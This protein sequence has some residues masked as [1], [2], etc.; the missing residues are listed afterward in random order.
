MEQ[1]EAVTKPAPA[2]TPD[3]LAAKAIYQC[4]GELRAFIIISVLIGV[5]WSIYKHYQAEKEAQE[6]RDAMRQRDLM[7]GY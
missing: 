7:R 5:G 2:E 6:I 3:S 1:K 4:W